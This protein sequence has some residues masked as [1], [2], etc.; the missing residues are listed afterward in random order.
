MRKFIM[1][2]SVII[3]LSSCYFWNASLDNVIRNIYLSK[4]LNQEMDA[5]FNLFKKD[6]ILIFG[7]SHNGYVDASDA[8]V[9]SEQYS[10]YFYTPADGMLAEWQSGF[11]PTAVHTLP[12]GDTVYLAAASESYDNSWRASDHIGELVIYADIDAAKGGYGYALN[13][14]GDLKVYDLQD[15]VESIKIL[16]ENG[17][18]IFNPP[19]PVPLALPALEG[20]IV[21]NSMLCDSG[22]QISGN[23]LTFYSI[24][25]GEAKFSFLNITDPASPVLIT[26]TTT[27]DVTGGIYLRFTLTGD[28]L[29][30]Y[31]YR[32]LM[33]LEQMITKIQVW[34]VGS[35]LSSSVIEK[36][37]NV[38]FPETTA[39]D[40]KY[41]NLQMSGNYIYALRLNNPSRGSEPAGFSIWDTSDLLNITA[42]DYILNSGVHYNE[43]G[44]DYGRSFTVEG[45]K[46]YLPSGN[47]IE[48]LQY[49]GG[50]LSALEYAYVGVPLKGVYK[51]AGDPYLYALGY[52]S[53]SVV[54]VKN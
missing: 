42:A 33:M 46:I 24:G 37:E 6:D 3:V 39:E 32:S 1:I 48:I 16:D 35:L 8:Q 11:A 54:S 20:I 25:E 17:G 31:P 15:W 53:I 9:A 2:F 45:D 41:M 29:Y 21:D 44:I 14:A 19:E 7:A 26:P 30:I 47:N 13:T 34:D 49:S 4:G 10:F 38:E 28:R 18:D 5:D 40:M 52:N 36:E 23:L 50:T 22:M 51:F 12:S 27:G 43:Y